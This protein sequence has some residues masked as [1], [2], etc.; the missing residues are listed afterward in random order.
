MIRQMIRTITEKHH[1]NAITLGEFARMKVKGMDYTLWAFHADGLGHVSA[2]SSKGFLGMTQRDT[3]IITPTEKDMP[4]F[5][6]NRVHS[7]R[8]DTLICELYDTLLE[9][10]GLESIERVTAVFRTLPEHDLGSNWYDSLK[11]PQ[12]LAKQAKKGDGDSLDRCAMD[13]LNAFLE[14]AEKAPYC[15]PAAKKEKACVYVEGLLA[16]GTQLRMGFRKRSARTRLPFCFIMCFSVPVDNLIFTGEAI[17]MKSK[18]LLICYGNSN[19]FGYDPRSWLGDRY[20]PEDRWV[21]ILGKNTGWDVRNQGMN[22]RRI[23]G[24]EYGIFHCALTAFIS[25]RKATDYSPQNLRKNS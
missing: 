14:E 18:P 25:L 6:Y 23:P 5:S 12:S 22:G 2:M 19:T 20:A 15:D 11:L 7:M 3:L 21:D 16:N 17:I 24:R 4:L 8:N 1:L 9:S 10:N 13:Y